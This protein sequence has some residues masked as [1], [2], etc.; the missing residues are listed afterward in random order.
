MLTR[1][2]FQPRSE[3][4]SS[5]LKKQKTT[6]KENLNCGVA[7]MPQVHQDDEVHGHV[8]VALFQLF[9]IFLFFPHPAKAN[10]M[11]Q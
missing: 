4:I 7:L 6:N 8:F 5:P 11:Y 9:L 2:L 1:S 3:C 10:P